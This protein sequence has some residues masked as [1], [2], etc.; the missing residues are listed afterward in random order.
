[1]T[2][3]GDAFHG[4]AGFTVDDPE[5][6]WRMPPRP[7]L[8]GSPNVLLIVHDDVG[9]GHPGCYGAPIRTLSTDRLAAGGLLYDNFHTTAM[10]SQTRPGQVFANLVGNAPKY[11]REGMLPAIAIAARQAS[12]MIEFAVQNNG[13]GIE[14][15]CIDRILGMVRRLHAHDRHE[16]TGT[17]PAVVKQI[18]E[19]HGGRVWV[20][21]RPGVGSA[22]FFTL[23]AA[24]VEEGF[25]GVDRLLPDPPS[26]A[27]IELSGPSPQRTG[28]W[29]PRSQ[30]IIR[31]MDLTRMSFAPGMRVG[32]TGEGGSWGRR[33][34]GEGRALP[35]HGLDP[36]RAAVPLDDLPDHGEADPRIIVPPRRTPRGT[37]ESRPRRT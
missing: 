25:G 15:G 34:E 9:F 11:R 28:R 6:V 20:Q 21:S 27:T 2:R 7:P 12:L 3:R 31:S 36:D 35:R 33:G 23:P 5:T 26:G 18:V 24:W 14:P 16:G 37:E 10:R 30:R 32:Q 13:I 1:M 8:E 29:I 22:S 19:R 17:G 4:P